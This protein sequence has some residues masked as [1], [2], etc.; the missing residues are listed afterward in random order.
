M[1][2]V[3]LC[4]FRSDSEIENT[5]SSATL[6]K[7]RLSALTLPGEIEFHVPHT[8][9]TL[10][11]KPLALPLPYS[12]LREI[13]SRALAEVESILDIAGDGIL[14]GSNHKYQK[15]TLM[16]TSHGVLRVRVTVE[17]TQLSSA[18]HHLMSYGILRETLQGLLDFA[19]VDKQ[20]SKINTFRI[21][22]GDLGPVGLGYFTWVHEASES[23]PADNN[24]PASRAFRRSTVKDVRY[25]KP[26]KPRSQPWHY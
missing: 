9:T 16:S 12:A 18:A 15:S 17:S 2:V 7:P 13:T 11:L 26:T 8:T 21:N 5:N 20:K 10:F 25:A 1:C 23:V 14:P 22:H 6:S 3:C 4:P 24:L 19:R